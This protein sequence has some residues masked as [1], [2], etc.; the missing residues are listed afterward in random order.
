VVGRD[1]GELPPERALAGPYDL[2]V[3]RDAVRLGDGGRVRERGA[4]RLEL[5]VEVRVE[6]QF[7][8]DDER[9]DEHDV[10]ATVGREAA[11]EVERMLGLGTAEER[12]DD[13]AVPDRRRPPGE[14]ARPAAKSTDVRPLHRIWYGTLARMTPG[15]TSSSRLM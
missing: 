2:P 14:A 5:D 15:S 10:R 9:R 6:R 13:A 8:R 12:N 4:K 11:G 7:L 3:G 1:L